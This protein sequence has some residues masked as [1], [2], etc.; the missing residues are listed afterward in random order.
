MQPLPWAPAPAPTAKSY[1]WLAL[2]VVALIIG[3]PILAWGA[4]SM[5]R[6]VQPNYLENP[7][8]SAR[9]IERAVGCKPCR[10]SN[11]TVLK[12]TLVVSMA[13]P[14]DDH[15]QLW[16]ISSVGGFPRDGWDLGRADANDGFDPRDVD[17]ERMQDEAKAW[18]KRTR[19]KNPPWN[20]SV[21]RCPTER[22]QLCFDFH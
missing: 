8:E 14:T 10:V 3:G 15:N 18:Q 9:A 5:R 20:V 21:R 2:I 1:T 16:D 11:I 12:G 17:W 13:D 6:L 4:F 22:E 7:S 19:R